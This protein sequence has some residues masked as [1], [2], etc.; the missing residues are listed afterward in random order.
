MTPPRPYRKVA[1]LGFAHE[2]EGFSPEGWEC[3]GLNYPPEWAIQKDVKWARFYQLHPRDTIE[4]EEEAWCIKARCPIYIFHAHQG[5]YKKPW[6]RRIHRIY[7]YPIK[8]IRDTLLPKGH[9]GLF[10]SSFSYAIAHAI[11]ESVKMGTS[12]VR[13]I[14]LFGMGLTKGTPRE[15]LIE[16]PAMLWWLGLAQG[17]G[18]TITVPKGT[19][20]FHYPYAYGLQYHEEVKWVNQRVREYGRVL[21]DQQAA[22]PDPVSRWE[23]D[24]RKQEILRS[25]QTRPYQRRRDAAP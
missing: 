17:R 16:Y 20:L 15:R 19:D 23:E 7:N 21:A 12:A 6:H 9:H 3:W 13:E 18:I 1:I 10:A 2:G 8:A 24:R 5:L 22:E 4:P 25:A 11:Y 14:G